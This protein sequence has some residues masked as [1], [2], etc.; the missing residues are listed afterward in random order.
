M[1]TMMALALYIMYLIVSTAL[2]KSVNSLSELKAK[3]GL[4]ASGEFPRLTQ[5]ESV[6]QVSHNVLYADMIHSL[7]LAL[8]NQRDKPA[9]ILVTSVQ[10]QSG[11]SLISE[12]LAWSA[13]KSRKTLLIDLDYQTAQGLSAKYPQHKKASASCSIIV[14]RQ[15]RQSSSSMSNWILCRAAIFRNHR[16]CC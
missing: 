15:N 16:C 5:L 13:S 7:R 10:S 12:L 1:I 2:D 4:K 6:K 9:T 14:V 11:S 8:L 3:T